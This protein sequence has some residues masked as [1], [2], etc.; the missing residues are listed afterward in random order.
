MRNH[1]LSGVD[2]ANIVKCK[3]KKEGKTKKAVITYDASDETTSVNPSTG[4]TVIEGEIAQ[5]TVEQDEIA[6][7]ERVLI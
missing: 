5:D 2:S 3:F 6:E 7:E 1:N 4:V